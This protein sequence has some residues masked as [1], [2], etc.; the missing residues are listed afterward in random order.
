MTSDTALTASY[1]QFVTA[2]GFPD[3][4][5]KIHKDDP[6]HKPKGIAVCADLLRPISSLS[7]TEK[8]KGLNQVSIWRF[9]STSFISVSS[10]PFIPRWVTRA[11]AAA[12]ALISCIASTHLL[13]GR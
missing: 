9:H 12:T 4:G 1:A 3:T 11:P 6:N 2:L 8:Q 10:A 5:F 13:K 7:S